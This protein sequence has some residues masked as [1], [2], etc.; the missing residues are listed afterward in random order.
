MAIQKVKFSKALVY[1]VSPAPLSLTVGQVISLDDVT[2]PVAAW[3]AAGFCAVD[4][5][6]EGL[7]GPKQHPRHPARTGKSSVGNPTGK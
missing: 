5:G 1:Y 3:I 4:A 6:T 2:Y 7:G